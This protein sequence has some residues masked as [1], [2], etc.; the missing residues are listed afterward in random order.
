MAKKSLQSK[1]D[2]FSLDLTSTPN[3]FCPV[4]N[5]SERKFMTEKFL[6]IEQQRKAENDKDLAKHKEYDLDEDEKCNEEIPEPRPHLNHNYCQICNENYQDF[7]LH[8][9]SENHKI[10]A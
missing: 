2:I 4:V 9:V 7:T 6:K 1:F 10:R 3:G 5:Q 8:L